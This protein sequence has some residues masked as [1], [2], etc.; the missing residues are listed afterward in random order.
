MNPQTASETFEGVLGRT[1]FVEDC[2]VL[3]IYPYD[4]STDSGAQPVSVVRFSQPEFRNL[5]VTTFLGCEVF[6]ALYG[7][8]VELSEVYGNRQLVLRAKSVS[9]SA[10][11]YDAGDYAERIRHLD[12]ECSRLN[13]A[14]VKALKK[15]NEGHK[16]ANELLRRAE[17]KSGGSE[18]LKIRQAAAISV[19][20]RLLAQ[21]ESKL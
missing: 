11:A 17:I 20:E 3:R 14:L 21:F 13:M 7:D 10:A 12:A 1:L 18:D 9:L 4:F 2:A 15:N 6:A 16:L 19:L 5:E 8:R